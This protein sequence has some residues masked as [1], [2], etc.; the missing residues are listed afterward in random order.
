MQQA[1]CLSQFD[2]SE[3]AQSTYYIILTVDP[4]NKKAL[5]RLFTKMLF[6]FRRTSGV[7]L[8]LLNLFVFG[9][10]KKL[11]KILKPVELHTGNKSEDKLCG[12]AFII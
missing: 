11:I 9:I 6:A 8:P 2:F 4:L 5:L 12:A 7:M 10:C 3:P 1:E